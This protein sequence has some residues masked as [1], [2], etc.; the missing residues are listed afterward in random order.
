MAKT[1]LEL[2]EGSPQDT[3]VKADRETFIEQETSG[4]RIRSLVELNNPLIYGNE[5]IRIAN[6]T[7]SAVEDMKSATG[8]VEGDGGLIG[9]GLSKLTNGKVSSISGARNEFNKKLKIPITP[10]PSRVI[11]EVIDSNPT[12]DNQGS[13]L[14]SST[15]ITREL[16]EDGSSEFGKFLKDTGGGNPKT[17]GRQA[18]GKGIGFAKDKLRGELFGEGAT[19][20]EA[21]GDKIDTEYSNQNTYTST[22]TDTSKPGARDYKKEGGEVNP[23]GNPIPFGNQSIDKIDLR[24]VS[25]IYGIDRKNNDN[26]FGNQPGSTDGKSGDRYGYQYLGNEFRKNEVLPTFDPTYTYTKTDGSTIPEYVSN[27]LPIKYRLDKSDFLNA[28][29]PTDDYTLDD[30][31]EF[32]KVGDTTY[33]DFV[34]VWIRK[35]GSEKPIVFRSILSGITETTSPSWSSNKF[36]GNPYSF[37]MYDGIERNVSMNIRTFASSPIELNSIWERL[38]ILTAYSYPTISGGL[39]TPP[40]I[41]FRLGS[42]YNNRTGFIESL[43]YTIPDDSNWETDGNIGYLPKIVDISLTIKFIEQDGSEDMLYD[44]DISKE[45]I[46]KINDSRETNSFSTDAQTE[47]SGIENVESRRGKIGKS[48][49]TTIKPNLKKLKSLNPSSDINPRIPQ[50]LITGR[51]NVGA[52]QSKQVDDLDGKTP[53]QVFKESENK[54]NYTSL[55]NQQLPNLLRRGYKEVPPNSPISKQNQRVDGYLN[56]VYRKENSV[57]VVGPNGSTYVYSVKE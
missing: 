49:I 43:S 13:K 53:V 16:F 51:V 46:K 34:P 14:P 29:S 57:V 33:S 21:I 52:A 20:G 30:N 24:K 39:T 36:I 42:I 54:S 47:G 38:K 45:A 55:Q 28:V 15:P 3:S 12:D 44:Y 27:S 35:K 2:F 32:I 4:I 1:L 50:D 10:I 6:R 22:L 41:E 7:T 8:G 19:I 5:A 23:N 26:W 25:P 48:G 40:I 18:L 31:N 56:L 11:T 17:I 37:Y 9:Q